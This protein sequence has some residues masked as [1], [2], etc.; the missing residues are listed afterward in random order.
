MQEILTIY[1]VLRAQFWVRTPIALWNHRWGALTTFLRAYVPLITIF[2][3]MTMKQGLMEIMIVRIKVLSVDNSFPVSTSCITIHA[4]H[5]MPGRCST[6][7]TNVKNLVI[8]NIHV[9]VPTT[10]KKVLLK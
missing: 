8:V 2:L 9:L 5:A 6:V 3:S 7:G 1:Y 10:I 4:V